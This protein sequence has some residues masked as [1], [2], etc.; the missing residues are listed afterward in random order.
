MLTGVVN[1]IMTAETAERALDMALARQPHL[2]LLDVRLR[3][4]DGLDLLA[5]IRSHGVLARVIV[6]SGFLDE[7]MESRASALGALAV[8]PKPVSLDVLLAAVDAALRPRGPLG[9]GWAAGLEGS[10]AE[11]WVSIVLHALESSQEPYVRE[12]L[13]R[14]GAVSLTTLKRICERVRIEPHD[15]RDLARMLCLLVWSRRLG[16][17]FEVLSHASEP[18]LGRLAERSGVSGRL[19]AATVRE[20]LDRQQFVAEDKFAFRLLR[21]A[22]FGR[23]GDCA[24]RVP[25]MGPDARAQLP[26]EPSKSTCWRF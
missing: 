3:N 26:N 9:D 18:T 10:F 22:L 8:L 25:L 20:L 2:V 5:E 17:P 23:R 16:V 19:D 4:N 14:R 7:Q 21:R 24:L 12:E 6:V 13:T 1:E 11:R 15:T